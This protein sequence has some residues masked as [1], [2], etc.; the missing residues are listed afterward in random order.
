MIDLP[1]VTAG[2]PGTGGRV[3]VAPEDFEVEEVPAYRPCGAGDHVYARIRKRGIPTLEAIARIARA[4]DVDRAR[5]GYAGLKDARA[6]TTQTLSIERVDPARVASLQ[7][8]GVEV[9]EVERHGNKLKRGHLHGNV[10]RITI[11]DVGEDAAS[12]AEQV[13]EVLKRRGLPNGF[14]PQRFGLAGT[15]DRLG[16]ALW[17]GDGAAFFEVLLS[18]IPGDAGA[19]ARRRFAAGDVAGARESLPPGCG[20]EAR[21]LRVL[22][23]TRGEPDRALRGVDRRL[24]DLFL[25]ACQAG[26]FN[27]VLAARL[28]TYDRLVDGDVAWIHRNGAVFDVPHA[29]TEQERAAAFEISPSGPLFGPKCRPASGAEGAI[30][31]AILAPHGLPAAPGARARAVRGGRRPLRVPLEEV[32]VRGAEGGGLELRFGLPP[33]AYA[34]TVLREV[35]K[36]PEFNGPGAAH[37][38]TPEG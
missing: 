19:E 13:L 12:R 27:E 34:T 23:R 7:V 26:L 2:L 11:R 16:A 30:E 18:G 35:T 9:L 24:A 33:G 10:F 5:V 3:R 14:G 31:A 25:N 32:R 8:D 15:N 22:E 38:G 17:R 4:L 28:E 29:A 20:S 1:C 21:A 6:V 37:V 36:S